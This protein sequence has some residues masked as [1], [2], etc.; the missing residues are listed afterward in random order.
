[1]RGAPKSW[2]AIAWPVLSLGSLM[3]M[4]PPRAHSSPAGMIVPAYQYPTTGTLWADCA[5]ASSR[6]PLVAV[7]NPAN[8][9]GSEADPHYLSASG[10]VRSA[11]GRVIGYVYTSS[12]RVPLD[13]VLAEVDRYR[14]WYALDGIY[15]DGMANDADPAHVAWHAALRESIRARE[16]AWLV[17]GSPG[18]NTL[19]E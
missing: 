3:V 13:G 12:A 17:V 7:M 1:M 5:R 18:E 15:L 9:P 6:V 8:G 4:T 10:A 16:P 11:G 2:P 19:P 14:E